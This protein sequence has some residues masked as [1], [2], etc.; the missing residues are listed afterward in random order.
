VLR[1]IGPRV[2][3][4]EN[5]D[6]AAVRA[7]MAAASIAVAPTQGEESFGRVA[8]EAMASGA[9]VIASRA[10]GFVEVVGEAGVLIDRPDGARVAEALLSLIDAPGLR[11]RLSLAGRERVEARYDLARA[12]MPFDRG[13]CG[14]HGRGA[15]ARVRGAR[16]QFRRDAPRARASR[17][18]PGDRPP[19]RPAPSDP[20]C[21]MTMA[22]RMPPP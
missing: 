7:A 5:A 4:T 20:P 8:V 3:V 2:S 16:H 6:H 14:G 21:A 1:R 9:A 22:Q 17:S 11:A 12:V 19:P 10:S 18:D 13:A 15:D